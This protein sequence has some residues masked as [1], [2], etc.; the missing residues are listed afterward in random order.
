MCFS[1]QGLN[2]LHSLYSFT[3]NIS[4][5]L[6]DIVKIRGWSLFRQKHNSVFNKNFCIYIHDFKG[7]S[8]KNKRPCQ[9]LKRQ[10]SQKKNKS[11][12]LWSVPAQMNPGQGAWGRCNRFTADIRKQEIINNNDITSL[13]RRKEINREDHLYILDVY[14]VTM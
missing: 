14:Q 5:N 4:H 3:T 7:L 11:Q 10:C 13:H 12:L 1:W 6:S 2:N 8:Y 9:E